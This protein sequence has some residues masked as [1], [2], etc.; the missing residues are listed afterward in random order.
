MATALKNAEMISTLDNRARRLTM[1]HRAA[2]SLN[3]IEDPDEMLETILK[4]AQKALGL[5][6]VAIL[7]P[8]GDPVL[9]FWR[10]GL[11]ETAAFT[12]AM[13]GGWIGDWAGWAE[14]DRFWAQVVRSVFRKTERSGFGL[15]WCY[16]KRKY[17]YGVVGLK[18]G[19]Y[20]NAEA[21]EP[22]QWNRWTHLAF[23]CGKEEIRLF[24]DGKLVAWSRRT[25][26]DL[27]GS[28]PARPGHGGPG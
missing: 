3:A 5:H 16:R 18:E 21:K 6:S 9:S 17:P 8:D 11:G 24:V 12:S 25:G 27:P 19:G 1:I 23:T 20:R 13:N 14:L 15:W 22:W 10:Y 2:C 28:R 7:T 26:R 4:L